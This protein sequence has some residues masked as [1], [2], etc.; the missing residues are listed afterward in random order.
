MSRTR[1]TWA[2]FGNDDQDFENKM[3]TIGGFFDLSA[4][5]GAGGANRR[6]DVV[7][8][9]ALLANTGHHDLR[10]TD[11]P[12]GY[13]G[14]RLDEAIRGY[15]KETGLEVDGRLDP[16]GP[17]L[18]SLGRRLSRRLAGHRPPTPG[19]VDR[20]HESIDRGK[21]ALVAHRPPAAKVVP[22]PGLPPVTDADALANDRTLD[23][24]R[25]TRNLGDLP[26]YLA[27]DMA[28]DGPRGVVR[29]R[30]L[31]DRA[32]RELGAERQRDLL[33]ALLAH[34]P[35]DGQKTLLGTNPP[36]DRPLGVALPAAVA[37]RES[38]AGPAPAAPAPRP[39]D[40]SARADQPAVPPPA[41]NP[42]GNGTGP[43]TVE[44]QAG[45][46][47]A[48]KD[49]AED[50]PADWARRIGDHGALTDGLAQWVA[51]TAADPSPR[52]GA[53]L[54]TFARELRA[55]NP[56]LATELGERVLAEAGG[57]E[58]FQV[59]AVAVDPRTGKP[60][61]PGPKI[62]WML[63]GGSGGGAAPRG[64]M[65][66][67]QALKA[68]LH[69]LFGIGAGEAVDRAK[70]SD[71]HVFP[72]QDDSDATPGGQESN[73]TAASPMPSGAPG[74]PSEPP[75]IPEDRDNHPPGDLVKLSIGIGKP[76]S[77]A[78]IP[79]LEGIPVPERQGPIFEIIPDDREW[80]N[81][82]LI[83]RRKGNEPIRVYN[84]EIA[85]SA[86]SIGI[87]DGIKGTRHVGGARDKDGNE[88]KETFLHPHTP[89][90]GRS[91][92][93]Q[94]SYIDVTLINDLTGRR[95]LLNTFTPEKSNDGNY[96]PDSR[97]TEQAIRILFNSED[98]DILA[99]L[100]KPPQ[101][102]EFDKEEIREFLRPLIHEIALPYDQESY[103][104]KLKDAPEWHQFHPKQLTIKKE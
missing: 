20:H 15:Q 43:S 49:A 102:Y 88:I 32:G 81:R 55:H 77:P 7:K 47:D 65:S 52:S 96:I 104:T 83:V 79:A 82:P 84:T 5:V 53:D 86:V 38:E 21:P 23:T 42:G 70:K 66:P 35:R 8:V 40:P 48:A 22:S 58:E 46:K 12:T 97:E 51:A 59:A 37:R 60:M 63:E 13:G 11:G 68:I 91:P 61:I 19:E 25:G 62:P 50:G 2:I 72:D 71:D 24:L 18:A 69:L 89:V 57:T 30:D 64:T 103:S 29:V 16:G 27:E 94:G 76:V 67:G 34:L 10:P 87:E 78:A 1:P 41:T 73:R 14:P 31:V 92:T 45:P 17:T 56:E 100:P 98:G 28:A 99:M 9:E 90:E 33:E 26:R 74:Y 75:E 44:A 3:A 39:Q 36:A 6:G 101:G 54:R 95:L 80:L 93:Y 4:P 85:Q